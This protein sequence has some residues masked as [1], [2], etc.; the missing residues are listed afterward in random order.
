M[1]GCVRK[2]YVCVRAFMCLCFYEFSYLLVRLFPLGEFSGPI[3]SFAE[4]S[5]LGILRGD[6]QFLQVPSEAIHPS[7]S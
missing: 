5:F 2:V 4:C 1:R 6:P 7:T 3:S